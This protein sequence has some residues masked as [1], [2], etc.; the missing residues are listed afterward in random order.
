MNL[1]EFTEA[2]MTRLPHFVNAKGELVHTKADGSEWS[3][4]DWLTA[5][6]GEVRQDLAD[7]LADVL[8]YLVILSEVAGIDLSRATLHKWNK[9]SARVGYPERLIEWGGL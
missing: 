5:L 1:K 9:V 8:T 3:L 6:V 7:E 2:N 4:N